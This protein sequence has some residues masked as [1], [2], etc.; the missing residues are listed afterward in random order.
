MSGKL[1]NHVWRKPH[2]NPVQGSKKPEITIGDL[3]K[4]EIIKDNS[5][6]CKDCGI[7]NDSNCRKLH[8]ADRTICIRPK[9]TNSTH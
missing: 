3:P 5:Y 2:S 8:F 4:Y 7:R 6:P 9:Q 1:L